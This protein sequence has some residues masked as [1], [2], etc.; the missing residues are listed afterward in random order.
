[1]PLGDMAKLPLLLLLFND[2]KAGKAAYSTPLEHLFPASSS[3]RSEVK[4]ALAHRALACPG[5]TG[6]GDARQTLASTSAKALKE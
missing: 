5:S 4:H 3:S 6:P 2:V 1:M